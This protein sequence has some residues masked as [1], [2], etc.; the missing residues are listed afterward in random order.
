[1]LRELRL[2]VGDDNDTASHLG[3]IGIGK[4][5]QNAVRQHHRLVQHLVGE[6][7]EMTAGRFGRELPLDVDRHRWKRRGHRRLHLAAQHAGHQQ[8][9]FDAALALVDVRIR[10][11][12]DEGGRGV[13]HFLRKVCVQIERG[14]DGQWRCERTSQLLQQISIDIKPA[15][16]ATNCSPMNSNEQSIERPCMPCGVPQLYG[17]A[18]PSTALDHARGRC[19][20]G[21]ERHNRDGLAPQSGDETTDFM[22]GLCKRVQDRRSRKKDIGVEIVIRRHVGDERIRLVQ[23]PSDADAHG[24]R[25]FEGVRWPSK[26]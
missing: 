9:R 13:D 24:K 15:R 2:V 22:R 23:H 10:A 14:D 17:K 26:S 1:M 18:L 19:A 12:T 6:R 25:P 20:G 11:I 3:H 16:L 21:E 7:V 8:R 4:T 5:E